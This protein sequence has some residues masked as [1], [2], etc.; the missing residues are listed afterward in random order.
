MG[1]PRSSY[2]EFV[3]RKPSNLSKENAE[4]RLSYQFKTHLE[5]DV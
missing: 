3:N 1:I 2:Y 5:T 4:K